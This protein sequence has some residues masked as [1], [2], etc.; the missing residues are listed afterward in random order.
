MLEFM[1]LRPLHWGWHLKMFISR[2]KIQP[3]FIYFLWN[4]SQ[5]PWPLHHRPFFIFMET[6]AILVIGKNFR[7]ISR[8]FLL[9]QANILWNWTALILLQFFSRLMNVKGLVQMLGCNVCLLEYRGYGHSDGS[10]HE[11]GCAKQNAGSIMCP[12]MQ[13]NSMSEI[14][15]RT[16][17]PN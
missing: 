14:W 5:N 13:F 2:V 3:D 8:I 17:W 15:I 7:E 4:K 9:K 16:I 11:E 12:G 1:C 10:P 6:L